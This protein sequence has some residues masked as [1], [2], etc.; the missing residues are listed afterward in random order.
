ML[1]GAILVSPEDNNPYFAYF[2]RSQ[3][4][5]RRDNRSS[6]SA[7]AERLAFVFG[8]D[9][10]LQATSSGKF[11]D[12]QAPIEKAK[13]I[14][15]PAPPN[16]KIIIDWAFKNITLPLHNKTKEKVE[17]DFAARFDYIQNSFRAQ[18]DA[19]NLKINDLQGQ[20][21]TGK[22]SNKKKLGELQD[23]VT[24][25]IN[26]RNK[27]TADLEK[28]KQLVMKS[29]EVLGCAYI[30]PLSDIEFKETFGMSRDPEAEAIA[31]KT[32]MDFEITSG[33][34]P[35]DVSSEN[36]GYDIRSV[37]AEGIKRYIE[38][39]G[40]SSDGQVM[41]SENEHNRLSQLGDTAWLYIVT[42]CKT[43]PK[44]FRIMNP[45]AR[46]Q[47]K[48]LSKGVQYLLDQDEWKNKCI[49]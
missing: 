7:A 6:D 45:G 27:R 24:S 20:Q 36:Q 26:K 12:M 32:A 28:M 30:E 1:K 39:K 25:L 9:G 15:P 23:K 17:K 41:L 3:I 11:I 29:P 4:A 38:V 48:Q 5:D 37:S 2:V 19:I 21:L 43:K 42:H 33:W 18:I 47:F 46:L 49:S 40:R 31:M 10:S 22:E 8:D 14:V 35:A 34:T 16:E 13:K 44:L